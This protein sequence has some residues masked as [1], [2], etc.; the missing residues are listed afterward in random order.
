LGDWMLTRFP[1]G[2]S[3]MIWFWSTGEVAV[4]KYVCEERPDW[5]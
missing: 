2:E 4:E 3:V 1:V 5:F